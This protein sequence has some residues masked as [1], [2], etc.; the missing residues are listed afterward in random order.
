MERGLQLVAVAVVEM[1][2]VAAA[3]AGAVVVEVVAW[4]WSVL[5]GRGGSEDD[6]KIGLSV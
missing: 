2:V 6:E 1:V 3:A 5:G 4:P